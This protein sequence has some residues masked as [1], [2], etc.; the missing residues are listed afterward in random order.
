VQEAKRLGSTPL[1]FWR[2]SLGDLNG[3]EK[4]MY[5]RERG[6]GE[7]WRKVR[8]GGEGGWG[9]GGGGGE[10]VWPIK[11]PLSFPPPPSPPLFFLV[12]GEGGVYDRSASGATGVPPGMHSHIGSRR[13]YRRLDF[14]EM[15]IVFNLTHAHAY[16]EPVIMTTIDDALA[17]TSPLPTPRTKKEGR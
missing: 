12:C 3:L 1:H 17:P 13:C 2:L 16:M 6:R 14:P 9:W 15:Q 8:R 5:T 11:S 7:G 10:G 4:T